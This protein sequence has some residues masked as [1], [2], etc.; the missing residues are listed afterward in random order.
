MSAILAET[1]LN[2]IIPD[3]RQKVRPVDHARYALS[4]GYGQDPLNVSELRYVDPVKTMPVVPSAALVFGYPGFWLGRDDLLLNA[5]KIAHVS[6]EVELHRPLPVLGDI[7]GRTRVTGLWSRGEGRGLVLA[8]ERTLLDANSDEKFAT[9][10][11]RHFLLDN[12]CATS[13]PMPEEAKVGAWGSRPDFQ[14]PLTIRPEQ[15]LLYRLNGDFNPLHSDPDVARS[16]GFSAPI[17]HGMCSFGMATRA[18]IASLC[19]YD[20]SR[21]RKIEMRFRSVVYPGDTLEARIW[22]DGR[23][24]VIAPS[25]DSIVIDQGHATIVD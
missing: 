23:F 21:L 16:A 9:L 20:S 3:A 10:R 22:R 24:E 25:R 12:W 8:S 1:L 15:A 6:Q 19:D 7:V 11:Q 14:F 18:L 17:L 5:A 2:A 13:E 4:I